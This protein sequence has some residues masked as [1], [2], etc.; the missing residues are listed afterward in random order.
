MGRTRTA[1]VAI[2][3]ERETTRKR[4]RGSRGASGSSIPDSDLEAPRTLA[5]R[6]IRSAA[7]VPGIRLRLA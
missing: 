4:G 1:W 5:S 3:G 6:D 2:G 7:A